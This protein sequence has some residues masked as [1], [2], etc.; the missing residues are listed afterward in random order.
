MDQTHLIA[1]FVHFPISLIL[2]STTLYAIAAVLRSQSWTQE[3]FITSKWCLY[4]AAL[5][6]SLAIVSGWNID[7]SM[8][9]NENYKEITENH[10]FWGLLTAIS[11]V[12]YG[13]ASIA[14]RK[15]WGKK[16]IAVTMVSLVILG[17][18]VIVTGKFGLD[19]TQYLLTN[20]NTEEISDSEEAEEYAPIHTEDFMNIEE[21]AENETAKDT[22]EEESDNN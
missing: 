3:L 20:G 5:V 13:L 1:F 15:V 19:K 11:I 8:L 18:L 2:V 9:N 6:S 16:H 17:C 10:K 4:I 21:E 22:S 12:I 14:M 7:Q